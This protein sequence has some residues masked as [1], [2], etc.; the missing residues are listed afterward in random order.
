MKVIMLVLEA[1]QKYPAALK[2]AYA[3][4]MA[5][6]LCQFM[7]VTGSRSPAVCGSILRP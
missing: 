5:H 3:R 2:G 4:L 7:S 6:G 1:Q